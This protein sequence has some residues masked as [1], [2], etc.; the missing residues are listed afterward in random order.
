MQLAR[1]LGSAQATIKHESLAGWK[2]LIAQPLLADGVSSDG[3]PLLAID[4]LGAAAGDT[5]LL[6]NDGSVARDV[7]RSDTT[8]AR[9]NVVGIK[10]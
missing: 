3:D 7:I 5:V 9:W 4:P 8:P 2:L 6:T 10:D 1:V